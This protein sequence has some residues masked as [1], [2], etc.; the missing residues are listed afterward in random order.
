MGGGSNAIGMFHPFINDKDVKL[1]GA[2]AGGE[3]K[4]GQTSATLSFGTP[5]VLHGTKTYLLQVLY[6]PTARIRSIF[7]KCIEM[8]NLRFILCLGP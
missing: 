8:I 5:G 1:I 2:E 4:D 3:L 6:L 7:K